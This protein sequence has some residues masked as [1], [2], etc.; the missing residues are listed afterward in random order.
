MAVGDSG[1]R[2]RPAA[3][4]DTRRSRLSGRNARA[5]DRLYRD[6]EGSVWGKVPVGFLERFLEQAG[7]V[8]EPESLLLDIA[9]GEGRNLEMLGRLPGDLIACDYSLH[10]LARAAAAA[11]GVAG[12][13]RC[14]LE[15]LPMRDHR[16]AFILASDILE[17]LPDLEESLTEIH[18]VL[19]VGGYLL[20][21]VPDLDDGI[22]G[23][24]MEPIRP[25]EYLYRE[26]FYYRFMEAGEARG[27]FERVG[28]A[29]RR[30]D[31]CSWIEQP[32]RHT[33]TVFLVQR[34]RPASE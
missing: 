17:T 29:I 21:N 5:W 9:C 34:T 15:N 27:L 4:A 31:R 16:F 23:T 24:D 6:T 32:H 10:G 20:A 2:G 33:S 14:V 7:E 11:D 1:V 13:V 25:H 12:L 18:R 28:F 22:A 30:Q 3:R 26:R 8:L 19:E